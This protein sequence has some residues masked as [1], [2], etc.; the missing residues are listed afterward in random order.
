MGSSRDRDTEQPLS[1]SPPSLSHCPQVAQWCLELCEGRKKTQRQLDSHIH[2]HSSCSTGGQ[3]W[4]WTAPPPQGVPHRHL[5]HVTDLGVFSHSFRAAPMLNEGQ[6]PAAPAHH[7]R[8][9]PAV[10]SSS[11][12]QK[13]PGQ[14]FPSH[15][16]PQQPRPRPKQ[17]SC[18]VQAL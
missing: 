17:G 11:P 12:S 7:K 5:G 14:T 6:V 16:C 10:P 15:P 3:H 2:H 1:P 4:T 8:A 13:P 9:F 18:T